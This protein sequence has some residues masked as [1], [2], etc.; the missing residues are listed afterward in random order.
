MVESSS[1]ECV[2][3]CP[4]EARAEALALLYRQFDPSLREL[5]IHEA[6][7]EAEHGVI[8]LSALWIARRRGKIVGTLL[9]QILA[10]RAGAVWP[11]EVVEGWGR[12]STAK[13]LLVAAIDHLSKSGCQI[14]Q[15]LLEDTA[16]ARASHDLN[17]GGLPK[18]TELHYLARETSRPLLFPKPAVSFDW[19]PFGP[20]TEAE[21]RRVLHES[22]GGSLDMPELEGIRS[23]DDI[24]AGQ[25]ALNR[26]DASR[27]LLG[28]I[29]GEERTAAVILLA[30][31][32]ERDVW[33][34]AYLGLTP[35][36][37]GRGL[38]LAALEHARE[39]AV[40]RVARLEL[41]VDERNI[42]A[43]RLY[44]KA[45]FHTFDRRAVHL[46]RLTNGSIAK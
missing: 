37:R 17:R 9:T 20:E 45:G 38:G 16:P 40:Q 39:L 28:R 15:A 8:D 3:L 26:F 22:Y 18:V 33:E 13:R 36:A 19:H 34:V 31:V 1:P 23:L 2:G 41:A 30:E 14:A 6:L 29:P 42:P 44:R 7:T 11:P 25:R 27:W 4:V 5:V 12:A 46:A 35:G 10:G 43:A 21:F 24:L 32:A